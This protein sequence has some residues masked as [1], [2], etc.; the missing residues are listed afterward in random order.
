MSL[1]VFEV[2][3][4][5][6]ENHPAPGIIETDNKKFLKISCKNGWLY[7]TDVQLEGKKRMKIVEF[8]RGIILE[9]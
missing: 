9:N 3:A 4:E 5:I 1:K 6:T 2:D 8:L 7:L